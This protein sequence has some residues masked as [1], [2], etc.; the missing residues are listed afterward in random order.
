MIKN[1]S[2]IRLIRIYEK[3][4]KDRRKIYILLWAG[5]ESGSGISLKNADGISDMR[6]CAEK[7]TDRAPVW[8]E[9]F[10]K[11]KNKEKNGS[12]ESRTYLCYDGN[13]RQKM[14]ENR[15]TARKRSAGGAQFLPDIGG[16]I[17]KR[18]KQ[19]RS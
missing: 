18:Q 14:A 9:K 3:Y 19:R 12:V 17:W 8:T 1:P 4:G 10:K 16:N 13:G 2:W 5:S 7:F 15:N 11:I 6:L